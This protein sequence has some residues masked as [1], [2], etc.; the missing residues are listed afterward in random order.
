MK[1]GNLFNL[2]ILSIIVLAFL[3]TVY[4]QDKFEGKVTINVYD[5]G[6]TYAMAY[7]VK[8]DKIRFDGTEEGQQGQVIIDQAAKQYMVIMPQQKMYMVMQMPD[9]KLNSEKPGKTNDDGKFEKTGETKEILGYTADKWTYTDGDDKGEVWMT[10]EIGG[11][12]LFDNPMAEDKAGWQKDVETAGYFPLEVYE[13]GKKVYEVTNIDKKALDES[14]FQ[15]PA[16]FQKMDMPM[17]QK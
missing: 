4:P 13:N 3:Q 12:S 14:M 2:L 6:Q 1:P 5:E 9:T 8:G 15:P 11:F 16:G 10:N 17:M 7:Y